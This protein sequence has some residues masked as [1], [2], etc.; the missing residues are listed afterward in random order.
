MVDYLQKGAYQTINNC[1]K[2]RAHET[3]TILTDLETLEVGISFLQEAK[4]ITNNIHFF[5]AEDLGERP[6]TKIDEN[7]MNA[8]RDSKVGILAMQGKE[9][10]LENFRRPLFIEVKKH[11]L[12]FANMIN[13]NHEIMEQ[14][15]NADYSKIQEYSKKVYDTVKDAKKIHVTTKLGTDLTASFSK[16]LKWIVADGNIT[17]EKWSNLPDGEVYTCPEDVNGKVVI[18][19]VLGDYFAKRYGLMV[20]HPLI[21]EIKNSRIISV[22]CDNDQLKEDFKKRTTADENANRVGEFAIGTNIFLKKLIG[23]LLQDEK[24]PGVHIAFGHGYPE[25]TGCPWE[26]IVHLDGVI[27]KPT[28]KVDKKIIMKE[29][30][31]KL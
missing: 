25:R 11:A 30:V 13:V 10:E 15:M 2:L 19:G 12:R 4:K 22:A 16:D 24:Y 17:E 7:L 6:L 14:G 31:F 26:S 8:I 21:I 9:T 5:I 28:I 27:L 1:L 29:G 18:D 3:I 23:R 20:K